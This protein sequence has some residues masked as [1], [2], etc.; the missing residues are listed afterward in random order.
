MNEQQIITALEKLAEIQSQIDLLHID[1]SVAIKAAIPVEIQHVLLDIET[2]YKQKL[3]AA[4]SNMSEL[5]TL[6]KAAV[7]EQGTSA[8]TQ[9]V[10]AV[11]TKGRT[12]WNTKALEG[13]AVKVPEILA[14]RTE[15]KPSVSIRW[16]T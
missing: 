2:E 11:L 6:I 16:G 7:L 10:S 13:Y 15:G 4:N 3:E 5:E 12:S 9:R 14:F 1:H 8:K